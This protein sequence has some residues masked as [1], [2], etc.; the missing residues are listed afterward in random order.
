MGI[1]MAMLNHRAQQRVVES[2]RHKLNRN[3]REVM[4]ELVHAKVITEVEAKELIGKQRHIVSMLEVSRRAIEHKREAE[5]TAD[6]SVYGVSGK[7]FEEAAEHAIKAGLTSY[8]TLFLR[9]AINA[10]KV[11]GVPQTEINVLQK[12]LKGLK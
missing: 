1:F 6:P 11:S 10:K 3:P 12:T 8:A 4:A 5:S 9:E 2:L 7:F